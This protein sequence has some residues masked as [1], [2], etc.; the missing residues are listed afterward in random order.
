M[1]PIDTIGKGTALLS[2]ADLIFLVEHKDELH[3]TLVKRQI[4]RTRTEME[5]SVL[6][7]MKHPTAASKYWQAV[8]EQ[9]VMLEELVKATFE[10]RRFDVKIRRLERKLACDLDSLERE[11]YRID[12]EEANYRLNS[13]MLMAKDRVRELREWSQ[14]KAGLDDGDFDTQNADSHQLVSY[15]QRFFLQAA[16]APENMP[17]AEANN[18]MGQVQTTVRVLTE[19]GLLE[20]ALAPL[21]AAV[22][23][24]LMP[25]PA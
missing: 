3:D 16:N 17:L 2:T 18:L 13:L 5:L 23:Q 4:F 21:P 11:E 7:D 9:A 19:R 6:N 25:A 10:A 8:R 24:R 14:I 15:A 20:Q 12:L 22:V 1:N